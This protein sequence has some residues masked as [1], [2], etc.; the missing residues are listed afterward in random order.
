MAKLGVNYFVAVPLAVLVLGLLGVVLQAMM[1]PLV[2]Q[3]NLTSLMIVTLG[4]GYVITGGGARIFGGDPERFV[5]PLQEA[6]IRFGEIW[7]TWQDVVTLAGTLVLLSVAGVA[8][9]GSRL[10]RRV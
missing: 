1:L 3:Q 6:P 2:M 7:F 8:M 4:F 10:R 5:S 9:A